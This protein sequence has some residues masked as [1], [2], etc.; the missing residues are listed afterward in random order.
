MTEAVSPGAVPEWTRGDRLR[1]ARAITGLTTRQFAERIGVS[2]KTI[3]DA[4]NDKRERVRKI[5]L[6]AWS[7]ATGVPAEWLENGTLPSPDGGDGGVV[8][9]K[10]RA[11]LAAVA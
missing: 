8:T 7:L 6:N 5:L 11:R 9:P 1:K 2:Q 4:E 10:Y 3:T